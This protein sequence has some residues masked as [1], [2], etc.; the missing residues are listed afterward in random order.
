MDSEIWKEIPGFDGKYIASNYGY[1][2]RVGYFYKTSYRGKSIERYIRPKKLGGSK[3]SSKGYCRINLDK[4]TY[5]IHRLIA[6]TFLDN[7]ENKE[8]VNHID[9]NKLN[10]NI[11]NLEWVSNQ[12]NRDH[13]VKLR[14]QP[15]GEAC[16]SAKLT[17]MDISII[18]ERYKKSEITQKE[19]ANIYQVSKG[20]IS[21]IIRRK[22]WKHI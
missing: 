20:C 9:G 1:I 17:E 12:E 14:L 6:I 15:V 21:S 3:L 18:R 11:S 5:F 2:L 8:Q 16:Y 22:S 10:N 19:L 4:K 13:A 7:P